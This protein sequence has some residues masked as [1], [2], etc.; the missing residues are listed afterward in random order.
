ME[1]ILESK[2]ISKVKVFKAGV[3]QTVERR[4]CNADVEGSIPFSSTKLGELAEWLMQRIAN[5][6]LC[7]TVHRFESY[8]LRHSNPIVSANIKYTLC[9]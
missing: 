3:A 1:D 2:D 5:P 9:F 6:S 4:T 8:T 7:I